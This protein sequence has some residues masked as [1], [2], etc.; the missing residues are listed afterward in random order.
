MVGPV[1]RF[2]EYNQVPKAEPLSINEE[3]NVSN[4]LPTVYALPSITVINLSENT[5]VKY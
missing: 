2:T 1:R 4:C 3:E 5:G